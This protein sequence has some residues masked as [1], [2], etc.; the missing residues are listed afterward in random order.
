MAE[1]LDSQADTSTTKAPKDKKCPYCD[2][3]FTSSSLGRHLDL[4]IKEKNPKPPDGIHDVEAIKKLRGAITRRQPKGASARREASQPGGTPSWSANKSPE[5]EADSSSVR[6]PTRPKEPQKASN[7][8]DLTANLYPFTAS[9]TAT[10]VINDIGSKSGETSQ[11]GSK[12]ATQEPA[13]RAIVPRAMSRQY[14]KAHL[15]AKQKFQDTIDTKRAAE[16]AL[17]ELIGSWR[18]AKYDCDSVVSRFVSWY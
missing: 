1:S 18:A 13:T 4:Y 9:W 3:A 12:D 15:E 5:S 10:G 11:D 16:L 6:S 7:P 2:Q 14:T 17:R 8:A